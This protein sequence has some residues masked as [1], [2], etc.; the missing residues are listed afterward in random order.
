MLRTCKDTQKE[1]KK[2]PPASAKVRQ[3]RVPLPEPHPYWYNI[4][5]MAGK[6][7]GGAIYET[8]S[9]APLRVTALP[10]IRRPLGATRLG[11]IWFATCN[12]VASIALELVALLA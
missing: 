6:Y 4:L 9:G 11:S 1:C 3:W 12:L 5:R 10:V 7:K 8:F 2:N